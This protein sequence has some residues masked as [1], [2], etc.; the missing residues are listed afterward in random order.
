MYKTV[1]AQFWLCEK[2]DWLLF[3]LSLSFVDTFCSSK[4]SLVTSEVLINI[5]ILNL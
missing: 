1:G 2:K 4:Q 3:K 5:L